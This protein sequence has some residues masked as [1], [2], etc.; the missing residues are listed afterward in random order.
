MES[1]ADTFHDVVCAS[2]TLSSTRVRFIERKIEILGVKSASHNPK[3]AIMV[4][5][6]LNITNSALQDQVEREL[7]WDPA[8]SPASIG[9]SVK[10]HAVTLTG[11]VATL[12]SRLAAVRATKRVK[13]V[14]TIADD[15]LVQASGAPGRADHDI[16]GF[17]EHAF[18][19]NSQVPDAVHATVREGVV[20]L[21]GAVDWNFQRNAAE[22]VAQYVS[23]VTGVN[24]NITLTRGASPQAIHSRITTALHR[25]AD[26]EADAI[27][28]TSHGGDVSLNGSVSSWAKRQ[29]V[30]AAAW[31]APGVTMVHDHITIH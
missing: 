24:N 8:V 19:W 12:S 13:G 16:A 3:G 4:T 7:L 29:R 20:T 31:A 21:D 14:R 27:K 2:W 10:D 18:K 5:A 26:I 28:V 9:V 25:Y 1:R 22:R 30:E 15:I 23:G 11:T 6:N 17:V